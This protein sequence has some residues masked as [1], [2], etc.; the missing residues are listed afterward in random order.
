MS[1]QIYFIDM[2][3]GLERTKVC[4]ANSEEEFRNTTVEELKRKLIPGDQRKSSSASS[5]GMWEWKFIGYLVN[6]ENLY[7]N[8]FLI[9]G[10]A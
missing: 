10:E 5:V 7:L 8:E 1:F 4:V 2:R 9:N 6:E 3:E